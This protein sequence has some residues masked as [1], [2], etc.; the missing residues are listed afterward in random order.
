MYILIV[1]FF[2]LNMNFGSYSVVAEFSSFESCTRA[3]DVIVKTH[4]ETRD[5]LDLNYTVIT[6]C[7]EK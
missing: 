1:L 4:K 6:Y 2:S 7:T 5:E 3:Q